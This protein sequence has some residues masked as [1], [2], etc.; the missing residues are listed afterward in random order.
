[1]SY[2]MACEISDRVIAIG[3]LA[4][5]DF[6]GAT[7][8]VPTHPL[9]VLQV[10]GTAD[11]NVAY[12]GEPGNFTGAVESTQR[13]A[14]RAGCDLTMATMSAP[15]DLDS[16]V[17]ADE[18]IATDYVIGCT[19]PLTVSLWTMNGSGHVPAFGTASTQRILDWLLAR[20]R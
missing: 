15:F 10:H 7:D 17:D 1:M 20:R 13:W 18:T 19:T 3:T 16:V 5:A 8:C 11:D 9:S 14:T 4:G 2:R 12:A 6:P